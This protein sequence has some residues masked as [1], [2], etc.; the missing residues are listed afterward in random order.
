MSLTLTCPLVRVPVN[1][2]ARCNLCFRFLL[3]IC[4]FVVI[5]FVFASRLRCV[6]LVS[7]FVSLI[8]LCLLVLV[9][10]FLLMIFFC[11]FLCFSNVFLPRVCLHLFLFV[12]HTSMGVRSFPPPNLPLSLAEI[13]FT[14]P[15]CMPTCHCCFQSAYMMYCTCWWLYACLLSR[16]LPSEPRCPTRFFG[17]TIC[18][19]TPTCHVFWCAFVLFLVFLSFLFVCVSARAFVCV[20]LCVC[21]YVRC[22]FSFCVLSV[23]VVTFFFSLASFT[24][25]RMLHAALVLLLVSLISLV[26]LTTFVSFVLLDPFTFV[27]YCSPHG[28]VYVAIKVLF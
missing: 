28:F 25:C 21:A 23:R 19:N 14:Y 17:S 20:R 2:C 26:L 12:C 9:F 7:I 4:A 6:C 10:P 3:I 13:A 15:V 16:S 5:L 8:Y 24:A 1:F 18:E 22:F 11:A 27:S